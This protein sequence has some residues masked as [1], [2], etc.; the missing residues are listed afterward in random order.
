[1]D[2]NGFVLAIVRDGSIKYY[3]EDGFFWP[4]RSRFGKRRVFTSKDEALKT[5]DRWAL[6]HLTTSAEWMPRVKEV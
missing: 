6:T 1:M 4:A 2:G 3:C 5:Y